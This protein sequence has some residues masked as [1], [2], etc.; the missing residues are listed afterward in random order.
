MN[1]KQIIEKT[2]DYVRKELEGEGSGHDWWHIYRVWKN[3]LHISAHENVDQFVVEMASLLHD[4]GD[5]KFH[6]GDESVGPRLAREWMTSLPI[7][8]ERI[9]H[10]C[11]IIEHLSFKGAGTKSVMNTLEG[12]IVQDADRLDAIGAIGIGRAFAYGGFAHQEMYNPTFEP[13]YH[14]TFEEYKKAKTT[15]IH[16]FYEKLLLLKDRMNL[17]SSKAIA[18]KRHAYMVDFLEQFLNEWNGKA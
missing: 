14:Q 6:Y 15:T 17:P 13:T 16:H 5:W 3:A 18:E 11:S 10:I 9:A 1:E 4:I 2:V 8:E 12:M 7:E